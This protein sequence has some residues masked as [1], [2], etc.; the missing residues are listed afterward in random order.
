MD[1]V[2]ADGS[3]IRRVDAEAALLMGGG[4]A[5]LMQLAHPGVA[6]GVHDHSDFSGDPW[7]R[8]TG[9]LNAM[10]TIVFGTRAQAEATAAALD[11]VHE[12]VRGEAYSAN[13]PELKLWVHATLVDTA[14]QVHRRF[15]APLSA[16]DASTYYEE[17]KVLAELLGIP[18]SLQ[19]GTYGDFR[20]FVRHEVATLEVSEQARAVARS[21]LHPRVPLVAEP[22]AELARQVTVGLCPAPL[23]HQYGLG[24]DRAR[25][26]A[27]NAAG[28]ASRQTLGRVPAPLRRL[29]T[30]GRAA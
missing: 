12:R 25:E 26:L 24:W 29:P 11:R 16:E 2:F 30:V 9:T 1:G 4:R 20:A 18:R 17:S 10:Y 3:L 14:V 15:L 19:P 13:D 7:R 5:L 28:L 6:A 23:R 21:V 22:V 27:L 8:L